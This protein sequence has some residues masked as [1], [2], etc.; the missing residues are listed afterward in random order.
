MYLVET[1][2]SGPF[3]TNAYLIG[4]EGSLDMLLVDAPPGSYE[5]V[6]RSLG[7]NSR[8]VALLITH[9]HF[10]HILDAGF[11]AQDGIPVFAHPD[12]VFGIEHPDTMD[13]MPQPADD[14]L[15]ARVTNLISGGSRLHLAGLDIEVIE[16]PGH[17]PGSLAFSIPL[18]SA[19]FVG[20]VL[21]QQSI[22]RTD[23]PGG[24][25]DTLAESIQTEIYSLPDDVIVYPGHGVTTT[26]GCEKRSNPYVR[27]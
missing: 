1:I 25:F 3:E 4:K 10:D 26:V 12:A 27:G 14:F 5:I 22:G 20:D 2:T 13:L 19:C 15:P 7:E 23:L 18:A 17:A 8:V 9:S 21:F 16:V 6:P 24:S 11:F